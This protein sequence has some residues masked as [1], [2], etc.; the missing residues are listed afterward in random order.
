MK[1]LWMTA[2]LLAVG[3]CDSFGDYCEAAANCVGGNEKDIDACVV[4]IEADEERADL[5][6]CDEWF[7]NYRECLEE[8]SN[9]ENDNYTP[10]E[11]CNDESRELSSCLSDSLPI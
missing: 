2:V 7:G 8:E 1:F 9:C 3:G 10:E 11:R 5:Y 4:T 6:G